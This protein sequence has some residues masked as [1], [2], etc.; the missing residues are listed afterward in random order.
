MN[1]DYQD[2]PI[3][4]G[5]DNAGVGVGRAR[6]SKDALKV[7]KIAPEEFTFAP[8]FVIKKQDENGT[9]TDAELVEISIIP[10]KRYVDW[11]QH[12]KGK[13]DA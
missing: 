2:I 7:F 11:Y 9:I 12:K 10:A 3:T 13:R 8:G 5:F 6:I 1:D 4:E